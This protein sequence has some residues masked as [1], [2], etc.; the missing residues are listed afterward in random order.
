[1]SRPTTPIDVRLYRK[2]VPNRITDCWEWRGGTN[3]IG[4]GMIKDI[5]H[6]GMRTTHRVSYEVSKGRIPKNQCVLHTCDNRKCCNPDHLFV[7]SYKDKTMDMMNKGRSNYFGENASEKCKHC[8][9]YTAP[10][11]IKRWHNDNC[12]HKPTK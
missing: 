3:N 7:G 1:M 8:D 10:G 11:L 5:E 4:Y 2:C 6:G 9:M 12:K